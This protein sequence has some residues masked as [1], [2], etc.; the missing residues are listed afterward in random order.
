MG[1]RKGQNFYYPPDFNYKKHKSLNSYHG[2]HALRERA[3]KI[4]EGILI[5]RFEMPFNVWCEKCKNHVGMGVRYNAEKKKIGMYYTT[6]LYEFKMKCHLCDNHYI[7]RTDPKNFDYE[8]VEGLRRQERRFDPAELDNLGAV[9]RNLSQ[10]LAGDAM[11][12]AEHQKEDKTRAEGDEE[13]IERLTRIQ[14]RMKDAYGANCALRRTF[15][16]E[17]KDLNEK[18]IADAELAKRLS[19]NVKL[20]PSTSAD[21]ELA[22]RMLALRDVKTEPE[23]REDVR[24][25]LQNES[26]FKSVRDKQDSK[27]PLGKLKIN[28][29]Q[30]LQ[31]RQIGVEIENLIAKKARKDEDA[32]TSSTSTT[33][34][35]SSIVPLVEYDS[36]SE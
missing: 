30:T 25:R 23:R 32:P 2:T 20:L 26:I 22:K 29:Q 1:E 14:S 11:L 12:K 16:A 7:I 6:P 15:R 21:S 31:K 33:T 13:Q 9:D 35:L 8:L 4:K 24:K 34:K 36:D 27:T 17:R 3:R 28:A 5:I 10:R 19:T 18:R